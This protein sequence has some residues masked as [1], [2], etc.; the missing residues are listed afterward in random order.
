VSD[1]DNIYSLIESIAC[2]ALVAFVIW[3]AWRS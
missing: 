2:M 1:A 3:L